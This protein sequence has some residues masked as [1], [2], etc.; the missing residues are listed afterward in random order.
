MND[1]NTWQIVASQLTASH[2][3]LAWKNCMRLCFHEV[4]YGWR[5]IVS[6]TLKLWRYLKWQ[7][8]IWDNSYSTILRERETQWLKRSIE[9]FFLIM[10]CWHIMA[11]W[12]CLKKE[13]N[14][15]IPCHQEL[16]KHIDS[17][18]TLLNS[19]QYVLS[20]LWLLYLCLCLVRALSI[21]HS[22]IKQRSVAACNPAY[23]SSSLQLLC[24][25]VS[26]LS[27]YHAVQRLCVMQIS[28]CDLEWIT[29]IHCSEVTLLSLS[30]CSSLSNEV[31]FCL[32]HVCWTEPPCV[33]EALL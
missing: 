3:F 7:D 5:R 8:W 10:W 1:K 33:K 21:F 26:W 15:L 2:C 20:Y 11:Q 6:F 17:F 4:H 25:P 12:N 13:Q 22:F 14:L 29:Q 24:Q 27:V 32:I 18:S 31:M 9:H 19:L 30:T 16:S 28:L 23:S